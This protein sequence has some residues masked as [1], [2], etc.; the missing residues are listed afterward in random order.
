MR[1][2]SRK[3]AVLVVATGFAATPAWAVA[4]PDRATHRVPADHHGHH[5]HHRSAVLPAAVFLPKAA[6]GNRFEIVTGQLAQQ[7]AQ[8]DAVKA[9]GAMFVTD[10]TAALQQV[11]QVAA[12][13]GI[14]LPAGLDPMQQA[15]V[16]RLQTLT[17]AEFDAAWIQAQIPAHRMALRLHL[18]A[19]IRGENDAIRTLGQNALPVITKHLAELLDI[20][21]NA[22]YDHGR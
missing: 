19:A 10:H 16:E 11:T 8:S 4:T 17:G 7:R 21:G 12:T 13:L 18:R 14:S 6:A 15:I 1:T 5:G 2:P 20:A 3:L 22:G 9:L